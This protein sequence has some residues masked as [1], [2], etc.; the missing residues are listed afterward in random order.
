MA[1]DLGGA[2]AGAALSISVIDDY[3]QE[4]ARIGVL[5]A[6]VMLTRNIAG[7]DFDITVKPIPKFEMAHLAGAAPYT[8]STEE[9]A[10]A[11]A[12]EGHAIHGHRPI[13]HC[14]RQNDS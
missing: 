13:G 4:L 8:I 14:R 10:A 5:P 12:D 6:S 11:V 9:L 3:V 2:T 1:I 7:Q